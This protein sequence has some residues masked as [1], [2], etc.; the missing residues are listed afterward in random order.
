MSFFK[1]YKKSYDRVIVGTGKKLY[2]L[3]IIVSLFPLHLFL[4]TPFCKMIF[5]KGYPV[6]STPPQLFFQWRGNSDCPCTQACP[7]CKQICR[8]WSSLKWSWV[9]KSLFWALGELQKVQ[10]SKTQLSIS[11]FSL[12]SPFLASLISFVLQ[13][14]VPHVPKRSL[15]RCI[16]ITLSSMERTKTLDM[17][18]P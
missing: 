17:L 9:S 14:P 2:M 8:P 5:P 4:L 11:P 15:Q 6:A 18:N 13:S 16:F 10:C 3:E 1:N 12:P 7:V